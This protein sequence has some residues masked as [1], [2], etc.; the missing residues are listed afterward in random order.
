[1]RSTPSS[2]S[3]RTSGCSARA[4]AAGDCSGRLAALSTTRGRIVGETFDPP[5]VDEHVHRRY[6][7]RN[8]HRE[9]MPGQIRGRIRYRNLTT[10][11]Q[12]WL[13]LSRAELEDL[14]DGTGWTL[15]RT[16]GDGPSYV[17]ILERA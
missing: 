12:D 16:L 1:V 2:S 4:P 8:V 13:Q 9:L 6:R 17:A 14:V 5:A 10:P 15:T 3:A 7:E 11:W